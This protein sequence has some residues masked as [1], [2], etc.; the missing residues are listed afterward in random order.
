MKETLPHL[1]VNT[2]FCRGVCGFC[3]FYKTDT[4]TFHRYFAEPGSFGRWLQADLAWRPVGLSPR[5]SSI[6][7]G[8]GS[9]LELG[10]G[11]L[12]SFLE[13]L[14]G[15]HDLDQAEITLE[16]NPFFPL[17]R[18][19]L[20]G[21]RYNRLSVGI[22]S[23][24]TRALEILHRPKIPDDTFLKWARLHLPNLS[25][26][27]LYD[28]PGHPDEAFREDVER[29]LAFGPDHLS[30]YSLE[31]TSDVFRRRI[32]ES[33]DGA[34]ERQFAHLEDRLARSG[35]VRYEISNWCRPGFES[36]H[37]RAYWETRPYLGLGPAAWSAYPVDGHW[38]RTLNWKH[39]GHWRDALASHQPP[40]EDRDPLDLAKRRNEFIFLSLRKAEGL[41]GADFEARFG[42]SFENFASAALRRLSPCFV[43]ENGKFRLSPRGVL[44]YNQVCADLM[45]VE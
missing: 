5:V 38:E 1:Y 44:Y 21:N 20:E 40:L 41:D 45:R 39:P 15:R 32:G 29:A 33:D 35:Y 11:S 31:V 4:R 43:R 37:N 7:I 42:E 10:E 27:L 26:D 13:D 19:L 22:Q 8:G 28:I 16:A 18:D 36:T 25:F 30:F 24:S 6:Y 17:D 12:A 34:F 14:H 2:P 3:N 9:P 23:F